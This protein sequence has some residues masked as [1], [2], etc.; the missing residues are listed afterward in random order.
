M[1]FGIE[2]TIAAVSTLLIGLTAA[3]LAASAVVR[4]RS[5]LR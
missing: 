3:V 4:G 2:P 1:L 5:G